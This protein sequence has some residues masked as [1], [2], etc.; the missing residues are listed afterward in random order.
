MA[1]WA[2]TRLQSIQRGRMTR[3]ALFLMLLEREQKRQQEADVAMLQAKQVATQQ[4][5]VPP[6][7]YTPPALANASGAAGTSQPPFL[8]LLKLS[9]A[10]QG[11]LGGS[12]AAGARAARAGAGAG[13]AGAARPAH[14]A[15]ER[16]LR[17]AVA[18]GWRAGARPAQLARALESGVVPPPVRHT[19]TQHEPAQP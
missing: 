18:Q 2:I 4:D 7:T 8:E 6:P 9:P 3:S 14:G 12:E 16:A 10:G 5:E 13:R 15:P 19:A 17:R 11:A 1:V